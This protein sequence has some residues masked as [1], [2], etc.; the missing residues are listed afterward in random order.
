MRFAGKALKLPLPHS[1]VTVSIAFA[2]LLATLASGSLFGVEPSVREIFGTGPEAFAR[3]IGPLTALSSVLIADG[4]VPLLLSL[5]GI[6]VMLGLSERLMGRWITLGVF[7]A[8]AVVGVGGGVLLQTI[9]ATADRGW[10]IGGDL[11]PVFDPL[12]PA[13]GTLMVASAFAEQLWRR[14]IRVLGIW[15]LL[16]LVLFSGQPADLYRFVAAVVGLLIGV[17][18]APHDRRWMRIARSSHH[19]ART[20]AAALVF[21]A[22]IAPLIGIATGAPYGPAQSL[23]VLFRGLQGSVA[24]CDLGT[25]TRACIDGLAIERLSSPGPV[26]LSLLPLGVL[27]LSVFG[28]LR[29]R[30]AAVWIAFGVSSYLAFLAAFYAVILVVLPDGAQLAPTANGTSIV[31]TSLA[32]LAPLGLAILL[33]TQLKHFP[34]RSSGGSRIVFRIVVT[35]T[36]VVTAVTYVVVGTIASDQFRPPVTVLALLLD[37]SE[38]FVPPGYLAMRLL[39]FVPDGAAASIVYDWVGPVF[40]LVV[41]VASAHLM[42]STSS[43]VRGSDRERIRVL[44]DRGAAGSLSHMASWAGHEYWFTADAE[45]AVAYRVVAGVAITTGGPIGSA[46][47][48]PEAIRDFSDFCDENGWIPAFYSVD[49]ELLPVFEELG[50]STTEVGDDAIIR[51]ATFSLAGGRWKDV[52][53]SINRA[54]KLGVTAQWTTWAELSIPMRQQ[55]EAISEEWVAGRNLP[56]MGFTLGG[57][58][59]LADPEVRLMLAVTDGGVVLA[60]TSWMPTFR[61]GA[62]VGWTLDFM[63]RRPTSMNGVIEFLIASTVLRAQGIG[64]EFVSLSAAPLSR[65]GAASDDGGV[66]QQVLGYVGR[67]LESLYGFRSLLAFK[68]KFG[69]E[70]RPISLAYQDPME[71]PGIGVALARAYLPAMTMPQAVSIMRTLVRSGDDTAVE[72][73]ER[74]TT[75]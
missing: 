51:P 14:R 12:T 3:G 52:R 54:A 56:E 59:E 44:L 61:E 72:D 47:A 7:F 46:S 65:A 29:G 18:V 5:V 33:V 37:L 63:R 11:A 19:E 31:G 53:T 64:L 73:R 10:W 43:T 40:W 67:R 24:A 49:E 25:A 21:V 20:L 22:A 71:L 75:P 58:D 26:L 60:A 30:R 70:F 9:G 1:A 2:V 74:V 8:T 50:W 66:A 23:S 39:E 42:A 6:M 34:V 16:L 69:P 13:I 57:V 62:L 28:L 45:A 48:R 17:F 38:R 27:A 41:L 35:S 4:L 68:V 36:F 32:V 15:V 55:I